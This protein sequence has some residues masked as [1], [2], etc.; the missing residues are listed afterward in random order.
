[1]PYFVLRY[2]PSCYVI[3]WFH[4][5]KIHCSHLTIFQR[6]KHF[7]FS[8]PQFILPS[9][10]ML[11]SQ[12]YI[13]WVCFVFTFY[14]S[15]YQFRCCCCCCYCRWWC[16]TCCCLFGHYCK[17]THSS[18]SHASSLLKYIPRCLHSFPFGL[19][20]EIHL[21]LFLFLFGITSP[22]FVSSLR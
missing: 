19:H 3:P 9:I 4:V 7:I 17:G 15:W 6:M 16:T 18:P 2:A 13:L 8:F 10:C 14:V 20:F 21:P 12:A 22:M 1:M 11:F 5:M